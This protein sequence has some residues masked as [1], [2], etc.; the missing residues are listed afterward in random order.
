MQVPYA[1]LGE[2]SRQ[3]DVSACVLALALLASS[4]CLTDI[5]ASEEMVE[6]VPLFI[7]A[8]PQALDSV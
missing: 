5:G 4:S 6:K 8:Q 7:K 3:K 2:Q 1:E